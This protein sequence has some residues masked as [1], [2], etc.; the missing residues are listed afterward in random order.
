MKSGRHGC[1]VVSA[2]GSQQEDCG[3]DSGPETFV[4]GVCMFVLCQRGFSPD[5]QAFCQNMHVRSIT[6]FKLFIAVNAS[7]NGYLSSRA[8]R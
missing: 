7:A 2:A 5:S 1:V 6:E 8:L 3:F 4:C